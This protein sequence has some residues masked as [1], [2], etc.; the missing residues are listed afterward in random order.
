M[1]IIQTIFLLIAVVSCFAAIFLIYVKLSNLE[2]KIASNQ[3]I[4]GFDPSE[5]AVIA[6][7]NWKLENRLEDMNERAD[8]K[9]I[10]RLRSISNQIKDFLNSY[11]IKAEDYTGR[12][13]NDGMNV[14]VI[15]GEEDSES[16]RD[17]VKK[18]ESPA[19]FINGAQYK[20]AVVI[21]AR[22]TKM[23]EERKDGSK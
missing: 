21:V 13:F 7:S 6:I 22:G 23:K 5:L 10:R 19:I 1:E 9:D 2:E 8:S 3:N 20:R 18:T 14:E 17:Y 12:T 11:G 15:A 16:E 4:S